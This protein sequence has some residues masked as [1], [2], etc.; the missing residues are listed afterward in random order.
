MG[1]PSSY[2]RT[3]PR[4]VND[5]AYLNSCIR[6]LITYLTGH[7]YDHAIAPKLL[8]APTS[9]DFLHIVTFLFRKARGEER[10]EES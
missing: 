10:G 2:V 1:K 6:T 3:D 4:P 7:G 8:T 9:K 5:K